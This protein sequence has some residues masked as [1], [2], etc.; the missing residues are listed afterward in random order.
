[1]NKLIEGY[2]LIERNQTTM[3]GV[4][5]LSDLRILFNC[6]NPVM[7]HRRIKLFEENRVLFRFCRGFYCTASCDLE[8]LSARICPDSYISCGNVLARNLLIGSVPEKTVYAIKTGH[9]RTFS[10]AP[11]TLVYMGIAPHLFTGFIRERRCNYAVAEKA[12]LDVLYFYQKGMTFSFDPFSDVDFSR[13]NGKVIDELLCG[14]RNPKFRS[15][16]KKVL[17]DAAE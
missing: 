10:G 1:M 17:A 4:Y 16:V 6:D 7:L 5:T 12:Y 11:G 8:S 14:Y 2:R 3:G 15:F 13:L 9:N